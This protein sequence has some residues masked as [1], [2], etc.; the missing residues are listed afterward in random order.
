[1]DQAAEQSQPNTEE[2][3]MAQFNRKLVAATLSAAAAV[4]IG[5]MF[6]STAQAQSKPYTCW[7]PAICKAVCGKPTCGGAAMSSGREAQMQKQARFQTS[8]VRQA[9]RGAATR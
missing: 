5:G 2:T 4:V 9:P 7:N 8:A 3:N 1:M 6:T